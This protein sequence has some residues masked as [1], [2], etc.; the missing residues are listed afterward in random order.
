M[1]YLLLLLSFIPLLSVAYADQP[2]ARSAYKQDSVTLLKSSCK[3]KV[4][5]MTAGVLGV[6]KEIVEAMK[7]AKVDIGG[8][9]VYPCFVFNQNDGN[10]YFFF[11]DG[12]VGA[13]PGEAFEMEEEA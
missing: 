7:E 5:K 12:D 3:S 6:P 11:D 9:V 4:A 1:K 8:K 2:V 10:V 13:I